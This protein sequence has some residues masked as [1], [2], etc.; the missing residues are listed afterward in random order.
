MVRLRFFFLLPSGIFQVYDCYFTNVLTQ[1]SCFEVLLTA[2]SQCFTRDDARIFVPTIPRRSLTG[3]H[4]ELEH[5]GLR[6][7]QFCEQ[8]G[9]FFP[10]RAEAPPSPVSS[11]SQSPPSFPSPSLSTKRNQLSPRS[12]LSRKHSNVQLVQAC[13]ASGNIHNA[14]SRHLDK[15]R[16]KHRRT[17]FPMNKA[18]ESKQR[19]TNWRRRH[20]GDMQR[21]PRGWPGFD[22]CVETK[23]RLDVYIR[24]WPPGWS[25]LRRIYTSR[26]S[27]WV[28]ACGWCQPP[29]LGFG[30]SWHGTNQ[31]ANKHFN[32]K[33]AVFL[34]TPKSFNV[35][36]GFPALQGQNV[37]KTRAFL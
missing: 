26:A 21:Q 32:D 4:C 9:Q 3:V 19:S 27:E 6:S 23:L 13:I 14:V 16:A 35:H 17:I 18:Q 29:W 25:F 11:T 12:P 1:R 5:W 10:T 36:C 22:K 24:P 31:I 20:P 30:K 8:C 34:A 7:Q 2:D 15:N 37:R 33:I 28:K